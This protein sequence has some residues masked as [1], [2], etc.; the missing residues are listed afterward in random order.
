VVPGITVAPHFDTFGHR[1]VESVFAAPPSPDLRLAGIDERTALVW[2]D[3]QW[4]VLGAGTV[5]VVTAATRQTY[6][7]GTTVDLP[8]PD[9]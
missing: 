3:G 1:W 7:A 6:A 5:T 2:S 9:R 4:T 8:S